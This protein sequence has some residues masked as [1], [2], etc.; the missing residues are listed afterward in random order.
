[1]SGYFSYMSDQSSALT[2]RALLGS[3]AAA[4]ALLTTGK[5]PLAAAPAAAKPLGLKS[6]TTG[7][8]PISAGERATRLARLQELMQ[9]QKVAALLVEAGSTLDYFTG[10]NWWLSERVTAAVIP[11]NGKIVIVTPFFERPSIEEM[12]QVPAEVRSWQED[13]S[14]YALIAAILN[15]GR[16]PAGALAADTNTRFFVFDTVSQALTTQRRVVSGTG[17]VRACRM[18]KSPAE[19]AL[20][21]VANEVTLAALRY[22][23]AH[24]EVGMRTADVS[25][26]MEQTTVALGA[27][28]PEFS[29]ALL[30]EASAFPHGSKVPQ[31][32]RNGSVVLMDCGCIVHGYQS[33]ISRT[34]VF[35]EPTARQRKVWDTVKR[36]Q[37]IAL[38]T[39]KIGIP[40]GEIDVAVRTYYEAEGWGKHYALPGLPHRTGHGIGLE[41]HESP[42]LVRNDKTPLQAGMCFS[43]EPGIYIPGEFGV[44]LEDCWHMTEG[45][46]KLF[47]PLARSLEDPI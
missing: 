21:S 47:T 4:S 13:E 42:Y 46:P 19:L 12:L 32:I 39:A 25:A 22:V 20:M 23:H 31:T 17:L 37:E 14:P 33:D 8:Q 41:G 44:R 34:W 1:M 2:R 16:L 26:L 45:G 28:T 40:V 7:A 9:Q 43:D 5:T 6:M 3:A 11:A 38:E 24:L 10:V 15:D 18:F 30:N 36:G 35:G 27:T 29:L